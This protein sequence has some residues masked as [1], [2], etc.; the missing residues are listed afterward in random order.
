MTTP[1]LLVLAALLLGVGG[2]TPELGAH[3]AAIVGGSPSGETSV[4]YTIQTGSTVLCA[5]AVVGPR[6]VLTVQRC[7]TPAG[8][9]TPIPAAAI[10]V[11]IGSTTDATTRTVAVEEI[12]IAPP[13]P[14]E[15]LALIRTREE[16]ELPVLTRASAA[17]TVGTD[18]VIVGYGRTD[19][20]MPG[21]K[22]E[23]DARVVSV[24]GATFDT[25]GIAFACGEGD[26]GGPA[27][28]LDGSL[29]GVGGLAVG[30]GCPPTANT[31]A[32]VASG[33]AFIDANLA[34]PLPDAGP[35]PD[36][37]GP[38]DGG[39]DVDAGDGRRL[40]D[41]GGCAV[42]APRSSDAAPWALW[43]LIAL[44]WAARRRPRGRP[45]RAR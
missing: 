42:G 25:A 10:N 18:V 11:G 37:G 39:P 43:L 35:A 34:P 30:G 36:A 2:C 33:A 24:D 7:V 9:D 38:G 15:R 45:T 4:V 13:G 44:T 19:A 16:L 32:S 14:A 21:A 6:D 26:D 12:F 1:R 20:A 41:R 40:P 8:S 31:Y 17:P 23:G 5:G 22:H 27:L 28:G 29:L 3:R